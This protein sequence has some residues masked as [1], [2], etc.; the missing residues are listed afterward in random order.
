M[1][2]PAR[3]AIA[4]SGKH[5]AQ[6]RQ[7]LFPG[8]GKEAVAI[9]LCGKSVSPRRH[10][11]TVREI[12]EIPYEKC[13]VRE[14]N[15]VSWSVDAILPALEKAMQRGLT[16]VKFHS[17]PGGFEK[18]SDYDDSSDTQLFAAVDSYL[19]TNSPQAS[20]VM[21][22]DGT[23]FGRTIKRGQL[24]TPIDEFRVAGDDFLFWRQEDYAPGAGETPEYAS[25]IVQTFGEGTYRTLRALRVGVVGCSG[26]GSIVV[27]QLARNC[28][29]AL[30]LVDPEPV[31]R[32]NLNRVL[33]ATKVDADGKES[34]V[35]VAKRAIDAM[36][37]GTQ[38]VT[39]Q[40]DIFSKEVISDLSDCDIL[41]GCV[42]SV[43][44]RHILNKVA[45]QFLIPF[46][47]IG[48]RIDADGKG[49]VE[50]ICGAIH[51]LQP[52]GSSL[53]SRRVY[54]AADLEAA[55]MRGREPERYAQML[56]AGYVRGARVDQPAVISLNMQIA[57]TAVNELFARLN[58]FRNEPNSTYAQRRVVLTDPAASF[59]E[60]DGAVCPVFS[61]WVGHGD[62]QP[63]LGYSELQ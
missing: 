19:E 31:E 48:V 13:R 24:G 23:F 34:K 46:I 30:V 36:G 41:F 2:T 32:K 15:R 33:N 58:P 43:D 9:A 12:I 29:G 38:V 25:R 7:H 26:T 60:D 8:D 51:S 42:D 4:I 20:V 6:L 35:A 44:A 63:L 5:Y 18:F 21:L 49:G 14:K 50:Q 39:H 11:T 16:V 54:T 61:K 59:D 3:H 37:L 53:L 22:P 56:E 28:V 1:T 55:F 45:T 27:E 10:I 40:G 47:D 57:A 17:H 62:Q 52:G